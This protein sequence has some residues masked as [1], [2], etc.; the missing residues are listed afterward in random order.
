[1]QTIFTAKKNIILSLLLLTGLAVLLYAQTLNFAY[2]WDD[3]LLFLD[4]TALLNE[5]LSWSLLTDPVL[6]GTTYMRPLIFL[7]LY[8]EFNVLGQSPAI[9]HAIN[10]IIFIINTWLVFFLCIKIARKSERAHPVRLALLAALFYVTHPALVE[11][12]AWVSGRFDSLVTLFILL[13]CITYLSS[14][15]TILRIILICIFF[16][17]ALLSKELG[18]LLPAVLI[19]IWLACY[20]ESSNSLVRT[21][22][23]AVRKNTLLLIAMLATIVFYL[24]LRQQAMSSMYHA[25]FN[26]EY[27]QW[28][29]FD[30]LLPIEALKF[31]IHQAVLPFSTVNP[32]HKTYNIDK[33]TFSNLI[34]NIFIV[35]LL[36][37]FFVFTLVKRSTASWLFM[38]ALAL[39]VP[40]LHIVPLTIDENI[41]HERFMTAP[42]ALFVIAMVMI[43][44]S[45]LFISLKKNVRQFSLVIV[46]STWL[47]L[48]S[49]TTYSTTGFW[50]NDLTL[51]NW[52][53]HK[54]PDSKAAR[55]NYLYG[56]LG[57][58]RVDLVEKEINK[59]L[60]KKQGL[61]VG[62]QLLYANMLIRKG[63]IEG[64]HY[65]EG[66]IYALP[67]FHE[68]PNGKEKINIFLLTA[69]QMAGVYNDYS[70]SFMVFKGDAE[71]AL[72]YNKIAEFYLTESEKI[73]LYYAR[74]AIYYGLGRYK[75]AAELYTSLEPFYY[76][77]KEL[78]KKVIP[79]LLEQFCEQ[80]KSDKTICAELTQLKII[81]SS[82]SQKPN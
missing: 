60:E 45:S 69:L 73:P 3:S 37:C 17:A 67:K 20:N 12:T 75:D 29:W 79:Q 49:W 59:Q 50:F 52:A 32:M 71:S 51:W 10:L 47:V 41:G 62:D 65:L 36:V 81:N 74:V 54:N 21:I 48:A 7:T 63:D 1:M 22:V 16:M 64:M 13:A 4:K 44:Y 70:N 25:G 8:I 66:V 55:Y 76:N 56:A 78:A 33:E 82:F 18:A 24:Y 68:M 14:I 6:P 11:S 53:L 42:L 57:A 39:I 23:L 30:N 2:V 35:S 15:Q 58:G 19:C 77:R 61:E 26:S 31:Y 27:R 28:A 9:S 43:D 34:N 40:V 72:K 80:A 38:A 46:G 5:P